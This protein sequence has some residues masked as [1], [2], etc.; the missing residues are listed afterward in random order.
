MSEPFP[1]SPSMHFTVDGGLRALDEYLRYLLGTLKCGQL[2]GRRI[3][4]ASDHTGRHHECGNIGRDNPAREFHPNRQGRLR[5]R[6]TQ[7]SFIVE[8][9]PDPD[10]HVGRV[11][12]EPGVAITVGCAG[13][14]GHRALESENFGFACS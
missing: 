2:P 8:S 7:S 10:H 14:P 9:Y 13:F 5:S 4:D 6:E 1:Y 11:S 3:D 12:Y